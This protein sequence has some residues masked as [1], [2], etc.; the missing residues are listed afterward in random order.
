MTTQSN[1]VD[2]L[3]DR[4]YQ[5]PNRTAFVFLQDGETETECI[6]FQQ[7][8]NRARKLASWLQQQAHPGER[9][10]LLC[11]S[12][13]EYIVGFFACLYAH[14]IAVPI[15]PPQRTR[16]H[17]RIQAIARDAQARFAFTTDE[18][19]SSLEQLQLD[20]PEIEPLTWFS[21][22][23]SAGVHPGDWRE[24]AI[25][26]DDLA[27]L[28]Y[29]SG[30]TASPKGVMVS[31]ANLIANLRMLRSMERSSPHSV[32]VSWLP[33][34]HDMGLIGQILQPVFCNAMSVFTPPVAFIQKPARWL[35]LIS[36]YRGT[37]SKSPNFGFDLCVIKTS[38]EEREGLDLSTW[39][40]AGCG[41][42]PVR[43]NT[44]DRFVE[45]YHPFGFCRQSFY[46]G[47]GLA[48]ATLF[49]SANVEAVDP[50]VIQVEKAALEQGTVVV[51]DRGKYGHT[52][53]GCGKPSD[54]QQVA[55]VDP[56]TRRKCAPDRIGEIWVSGAH[57]TQGYWGNPME[58]ERTFH[59]YIEG[60]EEGPFMRTGDLGFLYQGELFITGRIKDLIILQGAN[61]YPQDIENSV[62]N[63]HP[64]LRIGNCAAFSADIEDEERLI[65]V[66]EVRREHQ[67]NI[68]L[69][70]IAH[71]IRWAIAR[72]HG[73]RPH[74]IL[75]IPSS[76]LPKTTSGK[77]QRNRC[78]AMFLQKKFDVLRVW[79]EGQHANN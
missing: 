58:T 2:H 63:C 73:L 35:H 37:I 79:Q 65:I 64:A 6:T 76:R 40:I 4:A 51:L 77:L 66:Q 27:F 3:Q 32:Y 1:F 74:A 78:R 8:D 18:I 34:F 47:Y 61:H 31:H 26:R 41:A 50:L 56:D 53:V 39:K 9:V 10:L 42:E 13:I 36:H 67:H 44:I 52:L 72:D 38:T 59:A 30:S 15:F 23:S 62:E 60:S 20:S 5:N 33:L 54:G 14:L 28:Q 49:V 17:S 19:L 46:P 22:S 69:E 7:L 25:K 71:E 55:I 11:P 45:T 70:E 68:D 16:P 43:A 12:G 29:T 57:I 24:P 75:L 21:E 48:E